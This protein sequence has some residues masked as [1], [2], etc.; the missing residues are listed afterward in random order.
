M[1]EKRKT[2]EALG[3]CFTSVPYIDSLGHTHKLSVTVRDGGYQEG[4]DSLDAIKL[5]VEEEAQSKQLSMDD[6][7]EIEFGV[8]PF[9]V[10][11]SEYG[12]VDKLM[13]AGDWEPGDTQEILINE[14]ER[15]GDAIKF[16]KDDS[17]YPDDPVH[18]HWINNRPGTDMMAKLF[19]DVWS[20]KFPTKGKTKFPGGDM[21]IKIEGASTRRTSGGGKGNVFRNLVGARRP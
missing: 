5:I 11:P 12:V 3:I 10:D 13:A 14:Y 18:T 9:P 15:A 19:T 21:I 6:V 17:P 16:Y 7:P 1:T 20:D 2:T 8:D 4:R